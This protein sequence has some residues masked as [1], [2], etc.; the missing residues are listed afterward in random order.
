[1]VAPQNTATVTSAKSDEPNQKEQPVNQQTS[2]QKAVTNTD[3]VSDIVNQNQTSR[4]QSIGSSATTTIAQPATPSNNPTT[5]AP[6][7]Q[8]AASSQPARLMK[9]LSQ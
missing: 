2:T 1:M 5:S 3:N 4:T 6:T 9:L 7:Q 8:A